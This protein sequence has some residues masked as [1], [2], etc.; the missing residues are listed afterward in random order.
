MKKT[1]YLL[2][3]LTFIISSCDKVEGPYIEGGHDGG[4]EDPDTYV[5]KVLI[6]DFTAHYCV[7]CPRAAEQLE[8]LVGAYGNKIIPL[9]LHVTSLAQPNPGVGNPYNIDFRTTV[10]NDLEQEFSVL[11]LPIGMINRTEFGG[12]IL[13][14][15]GNWSSAVSEILS[16]TPKIGLKL[17]YT[18]DTINKKLGLEVSIKALENILATDKVLKLCAYITESKIIGGQKDENATGGEIINYEFNHV[19]R[20]SCNGTW[21][22][23]ITDDDFIKN[24]TIEKSLTNVSIDSDWDFHNLGAVVFVYDSLTNEVVQAENIELEVH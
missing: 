22:E 17:D 6:E 1:I 23:R 14:G 7:N 20:S 12:G 11:G 10:G 19:L 13:V 5:Q 15:D 18:I 16:Q 3:A 8:E 21:G 9:A 2:I 4:G 24:T